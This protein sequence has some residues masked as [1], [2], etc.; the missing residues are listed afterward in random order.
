MA[1]ASGPACQHATDDHPALL[2][3]HC[4]SDQLLL[5]D[6]IKS[7]KERVSLFSGGERFKKPNFHMALLQAPLASFAA[8]SKKENNV[9]H[10]T[11][12]KFLWD[13]VSEPQI[14]IFGHGPVFLSFYRTF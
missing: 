14:R 4:D 8:A 2:P 11:V 12:G 10:F 6:K 9:I 13:A 3:S 7:L 1:V 5:N